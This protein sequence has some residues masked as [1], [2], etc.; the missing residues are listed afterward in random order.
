MDKAH[1]PCFRN[2]WSS[3]ACLWDG[4]RGKDLLADPNVLQKPVL[5][6]IVSVCLRADPGLP[7]LPLPVWTLG[8]HYR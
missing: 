5:R 2:V 8:H 1:G 3:H 6:L 7:F 4:H